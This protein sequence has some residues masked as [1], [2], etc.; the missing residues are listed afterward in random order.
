VNAA[1]VDSIARAV[2]YEG[3]MLYPYRPSA[4]KNRQR[5]NF[6]VVYPKWY[7]EAQGGTDSWQMQTECLLRA[8]EMTQC[9]VRVRFLRLVTRS[10]GKL[11]TPMEDPNALPGAD[12][13]KVDRLQAGA[14]SYQPWQEACEE[15]IEVAE[16]NV[17]ALGSRPTQW[18]FQLSAK[19][20]T[21][22]IRDATRMIIGVVIREKESIAGM[23]EISAHSVR[24]GLFRLNALISNTT[25]T[26]AIDPSTRDEALARSLVSAHTVLEARGGDRSAR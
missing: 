25:R 11:Q 6:G 2:L 15:E 1:L 3:Y 18:P 7:S 5:F 23:I 22:P 9:I 13:Q 10:I 4:I 8:N 26:N 20:D 16:F 24:D 14:T 19:S 21:E 12:I 17:S